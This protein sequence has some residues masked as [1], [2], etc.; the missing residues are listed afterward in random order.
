[1][2][3]DGKRGPVNTSSVVVNRNGRIPGMCNFC[4]YLTRS[5]EAE[6]VTAVR[7]PASSHCLPN[8]ASLPTQRLNTP[9]PTFRLNTAHTRCPDSFPPTTTCHRLLRVP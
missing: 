8:A 2:D 9:H 6:S 1:M 5:I 4:L 7:V 3:G